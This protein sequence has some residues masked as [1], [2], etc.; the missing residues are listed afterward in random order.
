MNNYN[1]RSWCS[2]FG[3][4]SPRGV[5]ACCRADDRQIRAAAAAVRA[6]PPNPY[7]YLEGRRALA[8]KVLGRISLGRKPS[9]D[10]KAPT[11]SS[12]KSPAPTLGGCLAVSGSL[13][14]PSGSER[15]SPGRHDTCLHGGAQERTSMSGSLYVGIL[16]S[17]PWG[18]HGGLPMASAA[19]PAGCPVKWDGSHARTGDRR[20]GAEMKPAVD[21]DTSNVG[22]Q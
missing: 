18:S 21:G 8:L 11:N 1:A 10:A 5:R 2:F 3:I 14:I 19:S 7:P 16:W 20:L 17:G 4:L 13:G 9:R 22:L 12:Q 15:G 6:R